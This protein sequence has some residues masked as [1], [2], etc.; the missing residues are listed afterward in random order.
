MLGV[1][2]ALLFF[3]LGP[4]GMVSLPSA[5]PMLIVSLVFV[6]LAIRSRKLTENFY[7]PMNRVYDRMVAT[8]Q[9]ARGVGTHGSGPRIYA[10]YEI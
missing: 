1:H 9:K 6:G 2:T 3:V 4:F 7:E 8:T 5:Y 10:K